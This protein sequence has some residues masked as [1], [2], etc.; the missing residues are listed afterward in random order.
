MLPLIALTVYLTN[1]YA[2]VITIIVM[3][4]HACK[5]DHYILPECSFFFAFIGDHSTELTKVCH[6][7]WYETDMKT[8]MQNLAAQKLPIWVVLWNHPQEVSAYAVC[9]NK[10]SRLW[11]TM[12]VGRIT[13][14]TD[15]KLQLW[16]GWIKEAVH[17]R[18]E[19][20]H[21]YDKFLATSHHYCGKNRKKN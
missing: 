7:F 14:L 16:I 3:A 19:G 6:V 15:H 18:N 8:V 10:T 5:E 13:W 4:T 1:V 21:T 17:I 11:L 9:Q 2:A 20:S 12:P